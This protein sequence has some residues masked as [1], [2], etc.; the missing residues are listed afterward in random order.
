MVGDARGATNCGRGGRVAVVFVAIRT[1][2]ARTHEHFH[3]KG[4]RWPISEGVVLNSGRKG[5]GQL[6]SRNTVISGSEGG[7]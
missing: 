2:V 4:S 7:K 6:G 3:Q 1:G 5:G